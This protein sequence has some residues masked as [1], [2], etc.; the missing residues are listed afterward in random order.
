MKPLIICLWEISDD[1][2]KV[3]LHTFLLWIII[4]NNCVCC[5]SQSPLSREQRLH[6]SG[7]IQSQGMQRWL[8]L[9]L[10]GKYFSIA[11]IFVWELFFQAK[12]KEGLLK[13]IPLVRY[14]E[15]Q[16]MHERTWWEEMPKAIFIKGIGLV[17]FV[18]NLT[19]LVNCVICENCIDL[20]TLKT[21]NFAN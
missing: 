14:K 18:L 15:H 16:T 11:W 3:L 13:R 17:K 9:I 12:V 10:K 5:C 6:D 7:R 19:L 20:K 21:K 1:G 2:Y 8:H 4:F